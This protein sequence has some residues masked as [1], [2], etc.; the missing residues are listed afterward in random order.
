MVFL[1]AGFARVFRENWLELKSLI[2]QSGL[3]RAIFL[4]QHYIP[5]YLLGEVNFLNAWH[6]SQK[7]AAWLVCY[8][9]FKL[10][11]RVRTD[12]PV[13]GDMCDTHTAAGN[14]SE[15][16][17]MQI[18]TS[19]SAGNAACTDQAANNPVDGDTEQQPSHSDDDYRIVEIDQW[20]AVFQK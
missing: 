12:S 3:S 5:W 13:L 17:S 14:S 4:N 7:L 16:G 6:A 1:T 11:N 18:V 20:S 9:F 19:S 8:D 2:E 15:A 10:S